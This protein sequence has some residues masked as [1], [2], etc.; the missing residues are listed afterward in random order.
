MRYAKLQRINYYTMNETKK[1]YEAPKTKVIE[2]GESELCV[3]PSSGAST[4]DPT[5][6]DFD[7]GY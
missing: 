7:W 3:V 1:P 2:M 6:E 5:E 4:E